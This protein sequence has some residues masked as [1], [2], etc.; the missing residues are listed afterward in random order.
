MVGDVARDRVGDEVADRP[1]GGGPSPHHATGDGQQGPRQEPDARLAAREPVAT[2]A[3]S[4]A[5][6]VPSR[7]GR[8][9]RP[10]AGRAS[11]MRSGSRQ[12]WK[13]ASAS[14]ERMNHRSRSP[15]AARASSVSTVYDAPPRSISIALTANAGLPATASSTIARRCAGLADPAGPACGAAAAA[16]HEQHAARGPASRARP[17]RSRGGRGG[18]GRTSRR[19]RPASPRTTGP[20]GGSRR[21]R[22]RRRR[23][24]RS[25]VVLGRVPLQLRRRRSAPR[26]PGRMP[27][28]R[29]APS[30]PVRTSSRWNRSA[31]SS[32]SKFV[33]ATS[34]SIRLPDTR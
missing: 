11:R 18:S 34:R 10:R 21:H 23:R 12:A 32:F 26:R 4:A 20:A 6:G 33:W 16:G 8:A 19:G 3:A 27:A 24:S 25:T 13:P 7:P 31:D 28:F 14:A 1:P 17:R 2:Q 9:A 15:S 5:A 22:P 30:I 29:S